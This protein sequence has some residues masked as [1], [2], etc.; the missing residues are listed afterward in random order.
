M[1]DKNV[2]VITISTDNKFYYPNL[3]ESC[4]KNKGKLTTLGMGEEWQG[5]NWKFKKMLNYLTNLSDDK[6][7]CFVDGYDVISCRD[8]TELAY[9]FI[10]L[11]NKY[12]CK[13]IAGCD[14]YGFIGKKIAAHMS[15]GK[16]DNHYLN[17]GTYIGYVKDLKD[18]ISKIYEL[19]P[20]DSADDQVLMIQYYNKHPGEIHIDHECK[21]FLTL[22]YPLIEVDYFTSITI[23]NNKLHAIDYK[24]MPFFVHAPGNGFLNNIIIK[25]GYGTPDSDVKK[26]L[27]YAMADKLCYHLKRLFIDYKYIFLSI[28]VI[29]VV[30]SFTITKN[31]IKKKSII[32]IKN[33]KNKT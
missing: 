20:S 16:C 7:V 26:N 1:V 29:L 17:S 12:K 2:E 28:I 3:V 15:F 27:T 24:S 5:Y 32:S 30:I 23:N 6:I 25:L 19:N 31:I 11:K 22:M 33:K 10:K 21:L 9:E 18:I 14:E 4:R 8:L 13:I